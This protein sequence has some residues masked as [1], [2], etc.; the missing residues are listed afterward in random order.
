MAEDD[1]Y[2]LTLESEGNTALSLLKRVLSDVKLRSVTR[3]RIEIEADEPLVLEDRR[4]APQQEPEPEPEA[5]EGEPSLINGMRE[6]R[7]P[8]VGTD[9]DG[10]A[11]LE[12]LEELDDFVDSPTIRQQSSRFSEGESLSGALWS[13]ADRG[14][15]EKKQH[16]QDGRKKVYKLT[17]KGKAALDKQREATEAES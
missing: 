5:D 2:T 6:E 12:Q 4:E 8:H 1:K 10:Y 16:P 14:L 3:I 7:V 9:T 13:L 15:I 11:I 17:S